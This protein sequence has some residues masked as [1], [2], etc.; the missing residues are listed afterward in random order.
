MGAR[1]TYDDMRR[2]ARR[3]GWAEGGDD[4][5]SD[6][7][8]VQAVERKKQSDDSRRRREGTFADLW[9]VFVVLNCSTTTDFQ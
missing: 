9:S 7:L 6:Q 8:D 1:F 2:E 3:C 5:S 4:F